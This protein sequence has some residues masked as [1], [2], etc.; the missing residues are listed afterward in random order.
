MSHGCDLHCRCLCGSVVKWSILTT[1]TQCMCTH[2][3]TLFNGSFPVETVCW[4]FCNLSSP[5]VLNQFI[6]SRQTTSYS[7][8]LVLCHLATTS[9][10]DVPSSSFICFHKLKGQDTCYSATYM[11]QTH[12][13]QHFTISEVAADQHEPMM[14]QCIMQPFIASMNGQLDPWCS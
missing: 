3:H 1:L 11:S 10:S 5:F 14:P 12:D 6:P 13:Q 7:F 2:T 8:L 9:S 4:F